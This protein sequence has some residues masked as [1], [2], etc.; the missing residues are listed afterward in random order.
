MISGIIEIHFVEAFD[1]FLITNYCEKSS[2]LFGPS[3]VWQGLTL[4]VAIISSH[5]F[6]NRLSNQ[7]LKSTGKTF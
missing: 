4:V 7:A 3:D 6:L 1:N 5:W 2:L